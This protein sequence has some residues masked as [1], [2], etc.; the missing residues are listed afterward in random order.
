M[1]NTLI[2]HNNF[3]VSTFIEILSCQELYFYRQTTKY[4]YNCLSNDVITQ[5]LTKIIDTKI[6]TM[7]DTK[8]E[9][10]MNLAVSDQCTLS[11]DWLFN[12]FYGDTN[13]SVELYTPSAKTSLEYDNEDENMMDLGGNFNRSLYGG[14][15]MYV[16]GYPP[17]LDSSIFRITGNIIKK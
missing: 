6:R 11:G 7:T 3:M 13:E 9:E 5:K 2:F 10:F 12:A 4:L 15:Q 1:D 14:I 8:Y 17:E 16:H